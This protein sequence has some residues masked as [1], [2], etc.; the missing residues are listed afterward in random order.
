MSLVQSISTQWD[1]WIGKFRAYFPNTPQDIQA[2][3][4]FRGEVESDHPEDAHLAACQNTRT[5]EIVASLYLMDADGFLSSSNNPFSVLFDLID[6]QYLPSLTV[7]VKLKVK[8]DYEKTPAVLVL[9]SHCFVETLK[10][11]G[12]GIIMACNP[13]YF[14][15]YKRLGMRPI[16]QLEKFSAIEKHRIGM[17]CLP[18]QEYLN[19]I[20]SPAIPLLR[21]IDFNRYTPIC[22]WYYQLLRKNSAL[23]IGSA[24]YP[25]EEGDFS[26]HHNIT[27]GLSET[28]REVFLK[29]ALVINCREGEVLITEND[30]GNS[31]GYIKKGMVKVLI[32]GKPLVILGEGDIFGEI[33][34]ILESNR[35]AQVVAASEETEVVLFNSSALNQLNSEA[36]KSIIWRNL[37]RILAQRVVVTNKLLG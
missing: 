6:S 33:A 36:D 2:C 8:K 12:L 13:D 21:T 32:G 31:F 34:F 15:M 1:L 35:T 28:G 27:E 3:M 10:V 14:Y 7:F 29:N 19:I 23:R 30:G 24:F 25:E 22:Q 11:G 9:M 4:K 18:D 20:N 17:I 37:A 26:G 16:S 5:G